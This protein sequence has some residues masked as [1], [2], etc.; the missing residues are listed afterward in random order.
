MEQDKDVQGYV[1]VWGLEGLGI[2]DC[3]CQAG[4]ET[5][6]GPFLEEN[7]LLRA[8]VELED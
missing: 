7:G 1:P 8:H 3:T 5:P 4:M 2:H 6:A